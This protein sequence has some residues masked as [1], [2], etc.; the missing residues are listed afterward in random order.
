MKP[1]SQ[2]AEKIGDFVNQY[3][4]YFT[5][6]LFFVACFSIFLCFSPI[7]VKPN[8]IFSSGSVEGNTTLINVINSTFNSSNVTSFLDTNLF[9]FIIDNFP[10]FLA[11][12]GAFSLFCY[13]YY[14]ITNDARLI[15]DYSGNQQKSYINFFYSL[16]VILILY[17]LFTIL[18]LYYRLDFQLLEWVLTLI[19]FGLAYIT[20]SF[21]DRYIKHI[22]LNYKNK[23]QFAAIRDSQ[24]NILD[25]FS[26]LISIISFIL[27]FLIILFGIISDFMVFS[28]A[29]IVGLLL[30]S[31]WE[32][33]IIN[34]EPRSV[35]DIKTINSR[36]SQVFILSDLERPII[37][38]LGKGDV[39]QKQIIQLQRN[40]LECIVLNREIKKS[41][42]TEPSPSFGVTIVSSIAKIKQFFNASLIFIAGLII[43]I[44]LA[45]LF[46]P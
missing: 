7:S 14:N 18:I 31:I 19:F 46:I 41:E 5:F 35:Y 27:I 32:I 11:I 25:L 4:I 17:I 45:N 22:R 8:S 38:I 29:F 30:I 36:F 42:Q 44:I 20:S 6:L 9:R 40:S 2:N 3:T 34:N 23:V 39:D 1:K 13:F 21:F 16:I 43:G 28:I 26:Y 33:N 10:I 15:S 37:K 24:T 12:I